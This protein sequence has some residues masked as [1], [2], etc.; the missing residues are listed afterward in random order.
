MLLDLKKPLKEGDVVRLALTF[1]RAKVVTVNVP[2]QGMRATGP[3]NDAHAG[4]GA[5]AR[6]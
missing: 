4:H 6:R 2:V 3:G 1:E 5:P